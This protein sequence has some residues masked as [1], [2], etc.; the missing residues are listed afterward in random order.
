MSLRDL[1]DGMGTRDSLSSIVDRVVLTRP[2]DYREPG[3][4]VSSIAGV[5]ARKL[6][7]QRAFP[8]M[9]SPTDAK[10]E[11]RFDFGKAI[12]YI[13][14]NWYF[15]EARIL[16]GPWKCTKCENIV[17]GMKPTQKHV[18]GGSWEYD[19]LGVRMQKKE[20]SLPIIGHTDG[21][22]YLEKLGGW[23]VL[24]IK[25]ILDA[26]FQYHL[27]VP[28]RSADEQSNMYGYLIQRGHIEAPESVEVPIPKGR[29]ILYVNKNDCD[30]KVFVEEI[31]DG[32]AEERI[33]QI[34]LFERCAKTG[35][36]PPR[37]REC[38]KRT[39]KIAKVCGE[40]DHCFSGRF[41]GGI[42]L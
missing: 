4:H 28:Y 15:G 18:C 8:K 30:E 40:K 5:C 32:K 10:S 12:H 1:I 6:L 42:S 17:W 13:Y 23:Y 11:R 9:P 25:S 21:L 24:E 38:M 29:V 35:E 34:D 27:K 3:Y 37:W 14:Q 19:E 36:M 39:D 41:E 31:E 22:L 20:W 2:P 33:E 7:F 16:F 26:G